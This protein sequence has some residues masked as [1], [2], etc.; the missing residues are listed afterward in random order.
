M[1]LHNN[2]LFR[3]SS[4]INGQWITSD[5]RFEVINPANGQSIASVAEAT[6]E[7][8]QDSI[9]AA[10]TAFRQWS[11]ITAKESEPWIN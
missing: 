1:E 9:D 4:Y 11:A 3:E 10:S 6:A 8:L 7:Q 2:T 5:D